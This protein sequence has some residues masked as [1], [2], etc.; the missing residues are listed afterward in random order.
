MYLCF[1]FCKKINVEAREFSLT[2]TFIIEPIYLKFINHKE[3]KIDEKN[4]FIAKNLS[5]I[6]E[7]FMQ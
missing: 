4:M 5:Q 1:F 6:V 2:P 3:I 7:E